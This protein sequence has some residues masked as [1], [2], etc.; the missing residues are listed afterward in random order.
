MDYE[1]LKAP[2]AS[3]VKNF[4]IYILH[5]L[6]KVQNEFSVGDW[7]FRLLNRPAHIEKKDTTGLIIFKIDGLGHDQFEKALKKNRLPFIR[8]IIRKGDASVKKFYS[9]MPS[10]T[11]AVQAE[12]FFGVKTSVPAFEFF[13]R[14]NAAI[15]TMYKPHSAHQMAEILEKQGVPLLKGGASYSNIYAGGADEARYCSQTVNMDSILHAANP[16]SLLAILFFHTGKILRIIGYTVFELCLAVIDFF[17]GIMDRKRVFKELK[18]I[19]TRIFICI[20]LRE[21]IR[22]RVKI[23]VTRGVK[24]IHASFLGY[25]E[26]AHRRG[27]GSAFAFWTLKGIDDVIKDVYQTAKTSETRK[28]EMIIYADHGQESVRSYEKYYG[29][30]VEY[31]VKEILSDDDIFSGAFEKNKKRND[32]SP[33]YQRACSLLQKNHRLKAGC[34]NDDLDLEHIQITTKGPLGH[35]YFPAAISDEQTENIAQKLV[36]TAHIPLVLYIFHDRVMAITSAGKFDLLKQWDKIFRPSHAY[37]FPYRVASDLDVLCRHSHAGDMVI[38]GWTSDSSALPI[39]FAMEN[40]AHGGP[41]KN[42]TCGFVILPD[43]IR[44]HEPV[45]RPLDLRKIIIEFLESQKY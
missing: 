41:G 5:F 40:G 28:Y 25:D 16:F 13:D 9:G 35:I 32:I 29:K 34:E 23:N 43:E 18:F 27:P 30:P 42:E 45:L 20:I 2:M 37:P 38:S 4:F 24:I 11:P 17:R 26:Q 33:L 10:T 15:V 14:K 6:R 7:S 22:F 36:E 1:S 31:A 8:Q 44:V 21:L 19:P 39:T 3:F 12:L